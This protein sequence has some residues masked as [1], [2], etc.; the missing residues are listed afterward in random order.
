MKRFIEISS[1]QPVPFSLPPLPTGWLTGLDV[2]VLYNLC[3]IAGDNCHVLEIGSW[4]GRSSCV[5]AY[6]IRDFGLSGVSYDIIDYGITGAEEWMRRFNK[7]L[8]SET[9]VKDLAPVVLFPGGTGALLKQNL[10]DRDLAKYVNLII[11]GDVVGYKPKFAYDVIFCDA[12]HG[13][14][15]IRKNI[16]IVRQLVDETNF[17]VV[18]DDII[19]DSD[20]LLAMDLL[21]ADTYYLTSSIA[22]YTKVAIFGKGRYATSYG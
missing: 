6:G 2:A 17:L 15:E 22:E 16:P 1:L 20:A 5:I 19:T 11:L 10:V 8:Y 21:G 14:D 4:I 13:P 9:G 18:C 12:T 7:V 3:K